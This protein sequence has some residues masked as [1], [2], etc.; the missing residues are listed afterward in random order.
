MKKLLI[1]TNLI[2]IAVI[3]LLACNNSGEK[4]ASGDIRLGQDRSSLAKVKTRI[5]GVKTGWDAAVMEKGISD[6]DE[7]GFISYEAADTMSK[8]YNI[9]QEKSTFKQVEQIDGKIGILV[10]RQ[11]ARSIWFS[12]DILEEY[13]A[14]IRNCQPKRE[15]AYIPNM[16]IRIYYAKYPTNFS[17]FPSLSTLRQ[18]NNMHTLFMVPTYRDTLRNRDIDFNIAHIGSDSSRPTPYYKLPPEAKKTVSILGFNNPFIWADA[19]KIKT[20]SAMNHGGL[21]PPPDGS[22]S[23]PTPS[24][25]H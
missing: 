3:I 1:G 12:L 25:D 16:G 15:G 24:S 23:F 6:A 7:L 8:L 17:R 9:D 18:V 14:R 13:I 2:L 19:D 4:K 20:L 22:G 11:D 5:P 10:T 21:S